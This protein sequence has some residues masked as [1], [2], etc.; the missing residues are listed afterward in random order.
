MGMTYDNGCMTVRF[1]DHKCIL[2]FKM[3]VPIE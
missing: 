3:I 1:S 2:L